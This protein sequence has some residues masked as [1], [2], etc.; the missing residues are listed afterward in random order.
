MKKKVLFL[1]T[2]N[3]CRSQLAEGVANHFLGDRVEAFSAGTEASFVN[4][5]AIAVLKEIGIDITLK[6]EPQ[7]AYYGSAVFGKCD[8]LDSPLGMTDYGHRGTPDVL[9]A[10]P[11]TSRGSWNAAH[12]QNPE[13]DKLVAEFVAAVEL[14]N[15]RKI[16]GRIEELLLDETPIIEGNE[17]VLPRNAVFIIHP[18]TYTP[19]AGYHVLG[20]PL[21]VTADGCEVL[22][23]TERKLFETG[24]AA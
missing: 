12:F 14:T 2:A 13:Y 8:W 6:I 24:G 10:A 9:L 21:R 20:D 3:S 18:N 19:L 17:T 7:A 4:P 16:A 11:L 22:I 5:G 15:Q 1:C 23:S